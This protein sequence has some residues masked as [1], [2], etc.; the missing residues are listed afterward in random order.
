MRLTTALA[1]AALTF[2]SGVVNAYELTT[3]ALISEVAEQRSVLNATNANSIVPVL[4]FDR[5]SDTAPF[6]ADQQLPPDA[7]DAYYDDTATTQPTLPPL[8]AAHVRF[9]QEQERNSLPP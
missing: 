2:V 1:I 8:L 6:R 9:F 5:L 3:H 4:G 7:K